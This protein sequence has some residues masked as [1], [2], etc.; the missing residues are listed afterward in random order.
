M[1]NV[2]RTALAFCALAA[3]LALPFGARAADDPQAANNKAIMMI[4]K[5]LDPDRCEVLVT[6]PF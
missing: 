4:S 1:T 5:D 6:K 2:R 3:T